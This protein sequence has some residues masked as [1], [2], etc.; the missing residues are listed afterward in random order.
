MTST[1][2]ATSQNPSLSS[3]RRC[4]EDDP[5]RFTCSGRLHADNNLMVST[6]VPPTKV[7]TQSHSL[8]GI[9]VTEIVD[10]LTDRRWDAWV[11]ACPD[12]TVFHTSHWARTISETYGF[13][14]LGLTTTLGSERRLLL[15]LMEVDSWLTGCR[16]ISLPFSDECTVLG[17]GELFPHTFSHLQTHGTG[18]HWRSIECRGSLAPSPQATPSSTYYVHKL[19]LRPGEAALFKL[20]DPAVRR[21]IRKAEKSDLTIHTEVTEE[22]IEDYYRLQCLTRRRHGLPPQPI[23][24]FHAVRHHVLER[25]LG[26]MLLARVSG[27]AAAGVIFF[28]RANGA[29][30]KFGASDVAYQAL[31]P[32]NLV[33]WRAIQTCLTHGVNHLHFGRNALSHA[34]LRRFKLSWGTTEDKI[35]Y[36]KYDLVKRVF[37]T[38]HDLLNGWQNHV[39]RALPSRI[40]RA[41]GGALYKHIA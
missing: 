19:D 17:P 25:G 1:S 12:A 34:C 2:H 5:I 18:K 33:L 36:Y 14:S 28:H 39:F 9:A 37:A 41:L 8:A 20:F 29:M 4:V 40:S 24:F 11:E 6:T 26:F 13:R 27:R 21:A 3:K 38:D 30:F 15:P 23:E 16:G 22:A 32:T 31:R 35:H 7:A 10:P